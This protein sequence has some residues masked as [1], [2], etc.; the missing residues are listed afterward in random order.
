MSKLTVPDSGQQLYTDELYQ[1]IMSDEFIEACLT[2]VVI[3][4][5][6]VTKRYIA[7]DWRSNSDH[8]K[9]R[10]NWLIAVEKLCL[11]RFELDYGNI[12]DFLTVF[13]IWWEQQSEDINSDEAL[14]RVIVN[15]RIGL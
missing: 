1:T 9:E 6:P 11:E 4:G 10:M 5:P 12:G 3:C 2:T 13:E 14:A 7:R 15:K 8:M